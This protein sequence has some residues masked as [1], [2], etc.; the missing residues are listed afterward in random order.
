MV[1]IHIS[2]NGNVQGL[3][4]S[5]FLH[6]ICHGCKNSTYSNLS[7]QKRIYIF[8]L[9]EIGHGWQNQHFYKQKFR[10]ADKINISTDR[11]LPGLTKIHISSDWN[12]LRR[13]ETYL[14]YNLLLFQMFLSQWCNLP[15][16]GLILPVTNDI[17][18][19]IHNMFKYY[20]CIFSFTTCP[21]GN[22]TLT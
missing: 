15:P 14:V 19:C 18:V 6:K 12:L 9:M 17:H 1:K 4:K 2:M 11:N 13:K 8:T 5:T 16:Q 21:T 7:G 10:R 3:K 20:H 22:L